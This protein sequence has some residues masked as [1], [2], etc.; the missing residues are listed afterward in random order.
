MNGG[1]EE[2]EA[3]QKEAVNLARRRRRSRRLRR[4]LILMAGAGCALLLMIGVY[5]RLF[6]P[7][8]VPIVKL[9][10]SLPKIIEILGPPGIVLHHSESPAYYQGIKMNAARLEAIHRH[11]HPDWA[12]LYQG[13][14]YYIGYHYVILTDGTI[15]QGRPEG[16]PGAH[17]RTHNDWIG[18]CLIGGFQ[19]NNHWWPEQPTQPQMRSLIGLCERLMSKYHIPPSLVKRHRDINDTWCPG[20]RFPY[21]KIIAQLSA[22]AATHPETRPAPGRIV[23]LDHPPPPGRKKKKG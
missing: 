4:V 8:P 1:D 20:D 19:S 16:C 21:A 13:K 23:S 22:Y 7:K 15:E 12:T 9:S 18:I 17:A 14:T 2:Y 3:N 5:R 11:E 10:P 6:A